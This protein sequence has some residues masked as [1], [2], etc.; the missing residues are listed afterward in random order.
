MS[1]LAENHSGNQYVA[2]VVGVDQ[3]DIHDI[4]MTLYSI[5]DFLHNIYD[6][7]IFPE[8]IRMLFDFTSGSLSEKILYPTLAAFVHLKQG[9]DNFLLMATELDIYIKA[10]GD[11][12]TDKLEYIEL[13]NLFTRQIKNQQIITN[14]KMKLLKYELYQDLMAIVVEVRN[15]AIMYQSAVLST[16]PFFPKTCK[17]AF[18]E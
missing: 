10:H 5:Q 17:K 2:N 6:K 11:E 1:A 13:Q 4:Q 8:E 12:M 16:Q 3:N 9:Y 14:Q 18:N 15:Y 7:D